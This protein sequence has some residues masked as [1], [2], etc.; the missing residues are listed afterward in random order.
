MIRYTLILVF[1][2]SAFLA[3]ACGGATNTANSNN[4]KAANVNASNSAPVAVNLDPANLPPGLSASPVQ[5]PANV[6]G[7]NSNGAQP[8]GATPTPGIPDPSKINKPIK[9][10]ATPTPGIP[11]AEEIRKML[12]RP[13]VPANTTTPVMKSN[14]PMMKS[15]RPLGGKPKP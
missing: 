13:G 15:N 7:V 14:T 4:A 8:R 9:P 10:G 6:P 5:R 3:L 11:S 2:L 12:A 1:C